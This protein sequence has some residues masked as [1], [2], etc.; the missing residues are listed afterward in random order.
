MASV[1]SD[2]KTCRFSVAPRS[3]SWNTRTKRGENRGSRPFVSLIVDYVSEL[4]I[5]ISSEFER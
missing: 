2:H 4:N 3:L 5:G 1:K